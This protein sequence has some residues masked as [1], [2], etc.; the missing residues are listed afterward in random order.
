[1]KARRAYQE[2]LNRL[3]GNVDAVIKVRIFCLVGDIIKKRIF[4]DS[5]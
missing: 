4:G 5:S 3:H 2:R 1:M